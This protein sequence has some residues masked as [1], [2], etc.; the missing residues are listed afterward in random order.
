[1]RKFGAICILLALASPALIGRS[2]AQL[3]PEEV[4]PELKYIPES[5]LGD[6]EPP[7]ELSEALPYYLSGFDPEGR[8]IWVWEFGKWDLRQFLEKGEKWEK[9]VDRYFD[10]WLWRLYDSTNIKATKE[11]PVKDG[12]L[13]VDFEGFSYRQYSSPA[14]LGFFLK[15]MRTIAYA[16]PL[17]NDAFFINVNFVARNVVELLKPII[18]KDFHRIQIFGT[19]PRTYLPALLKALPKD[20]LPEWYGG[21]KDFKPV[22]VYG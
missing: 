7:K 19:N 1:M 20:Q 18:G 12:E 15:K 14:A 10:K 5:D 9:L 2:G 13:I 16:L 8:P 3:T 21:D 17:A 11:L 4:P 6:W 22:K